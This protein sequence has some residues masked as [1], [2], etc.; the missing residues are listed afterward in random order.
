MKATASLLVILIRDIARAEREGRCTEE[1]LA[2]AAE[3]LEPKPATEPAAQESA[4]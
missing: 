3:L 1:Y 4:A 2:S